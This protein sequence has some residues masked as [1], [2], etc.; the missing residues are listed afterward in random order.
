M[1]NIKFTEL[2]TLFMRFAYSLISLS[3]CLQLRS[4]SSSTS[5][6]QVTSKSTVVNTYIAFRAYG[7]C[8]G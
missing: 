8:A 6:L 2:L 5:A 3:Q 1:N 7:V 4:L